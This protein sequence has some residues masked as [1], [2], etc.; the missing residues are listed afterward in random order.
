MSDMSSFRQVKRPRQWDAG[1][2]ALPTTGVATPRVRRLTH[3][4]KMAS[5][6]DRSFALLGS[7]AD[8]GFPGRKWLRVVWHRA[9]NGFSCR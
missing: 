1:S 6:A 7:G 2:C 8:N 9:D 3:V 5:R 4:P